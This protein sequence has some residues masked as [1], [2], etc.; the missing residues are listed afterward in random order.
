MKATESY[1]IVFLN[2]YVN[3][4]GVTMYKY[5]L[6][7]EDFTSYKIAQGN[8]YREFQGKPLYFSKHNLGKE[9]SIYHSLPRGFSSEEYIG[10]Y[11]PDKGCCPKC[12]SSVNLKFGD[13]EDGQ[14]TIL[15]EKCNP[16]KYMIQD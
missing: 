2:T 8:Y 3:S 10:G 7:G 11:F 13:V 5:Q 16:I 6:Q 12:K 9:Y 4:K 1:E 14:V 15:C